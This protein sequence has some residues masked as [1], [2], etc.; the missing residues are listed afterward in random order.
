MPHRNIAMKIM[1]FWHPRGRGVFLTIMAVPLFVTVYFLIFLDLDIMN[2]QSR[3]GSRPNYGTTNGRS[4][5]KTIVK[6]QR[7]LDDLGRDLSNVITHRDHIRFKI[8]ALI[9]ETTQWS[10]NK[11][12]V[13]ELRMVLDNV[14]FHNYTS[15][16]KQ[17]LFITCNQIEAIQQLSKP[18]WRDAYSY[19]EDGLYGFQQVKTI[20]SRTDL[21]TCSAVSH[22]DNSKACRIYANN[23][24]LRDIMLF[25]QLQ[26]T[27]FGKLLGYCVREFSSGVSYVIGNG[28]NLNITEISSL[29]WKK[30]VQVC[31]KFIFRLLRNGNYRN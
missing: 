6:M 17:R 20:R 24:A 1:S 12:F 31:Y 22:R 7:A 21:K 4:F 15:V 13:D 26:H 3:S 5:I 28:R 8:K 2:A 30:K 23:L 27:G 29:S 9:N 16:V 14:Y 25:E 10:R 18:R 19:T 11:Y